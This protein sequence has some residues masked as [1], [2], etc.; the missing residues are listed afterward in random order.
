MFLYLRSSSVC[1]IPLYRVLLVVSLLSSGLF[2]GFLLGWGLTFNTSEGCRPLALSPP[3]VYIC[4]R[5]DDICCASCP[6][7]GCLSTAT[8]C[9]RSPPTL[10]P[11]NLMD[12][13]TNPS[14]ST[15]ME[16]SDY[17]AHGSM[18][19]FRIVQLLTN[20]VRES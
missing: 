13:F 16:P 12:M 8:C 18:S 20:V 11:T 5:T 14:S 6:C 10:L 9:D 1:L 3:S 15:V 7:L 19:V 17:G 2:A 4:I